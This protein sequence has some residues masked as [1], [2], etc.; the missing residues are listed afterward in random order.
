MENL[1]DTKQAA[2]I[3]GVSMQSVVRLI[4]RGVIKCIRKNGKKYFDKQNILAVKKQRDDD[5]GM[6]E[7]KLQKIDEY[8]IAVDV[9]ENAFTPKTVGQL[10]LVTGLLE[11]KIEHIVNVLRPDLFMMAD[12]KIQS[13]MLDHDDEE[14]RK[15]KEVHKRKKSKPCQN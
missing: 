2:F 12:G 7:A 6:S 4:D 9:W 13:V 10:S 14:K 15:K 11:S 8:A 3:L 5:L 1:I